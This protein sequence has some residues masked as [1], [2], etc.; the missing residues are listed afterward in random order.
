MH[1]VTSLRNLVVV[2]AAVGEDRGAAILAAAAT[3]PRLRPSYGPE[4]AH[5]AALLSALEARV[6]TTLFTEW[7]AHGRRLDVDQA[8]NTALELLEQRRS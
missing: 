5:L 7:S 4:W 1:A 2:L 6:G 3:N 8:L